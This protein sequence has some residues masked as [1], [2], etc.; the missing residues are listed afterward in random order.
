MPHLLRL[1]TIQR[2]KSV[3]LMIRP[4]SLLLLPKPPGFCSFPFAKPVRFPARQNEGTY[5]CGALIL[6]AS[7]GSRYNTLHFASKVVCQRD[8]LWKPSC[9]G[10]CSHTSS[11]T[12]NKRH[13]PARFPVLI[14][15][16]CLPIWASYAIAH[17]NRSNLSLPY[18][19]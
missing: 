7:R 19:L 1:K 5:P 4:I 2:S 15:A 3:W 18:V 9:V 8:T 12:Q 13:R 6:P 17:I 16:V 10:M 14:Y 11:K